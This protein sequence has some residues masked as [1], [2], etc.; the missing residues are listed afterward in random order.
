MSD[1]KSEYGLTPASV[2]RWI[3]EGIFPVPVNIG[4]NSVAWHREEIENWRKSRPRANIRR[5]SSQK[6]SEHGD[7]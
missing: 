7:Q 6:N 5:I 2:Y 3:G 4:R 1:L